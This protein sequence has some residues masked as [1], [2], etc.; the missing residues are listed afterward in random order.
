MIYIFLFLLPVFL[1]LAIS[2]AIKFVY[3]RLAFYFLV[4]ILGL[5]AYG[6]G[7]M[8]VFILLWVGMGIVIYMERGKK[9]NFPLRNVAIGT[10]LFLSAILIGNYTGVVTLDAGQA[11]VRFWPAI[12]FILGLIYLLNPR[13]KNNAGLVL[14]ELSAIFIALNLLFFAGDDF[15]WQHPA[16]FMALIAFWPLFFLLLAVQAFRGWMASGDENY[17]AFF[18]RLTVDNQKAKK[19]DS[20]LNKLFSKIN[21]LLPGLSGW[22]P[23][24]SSFLAFMGKITIKLSHQDL[25]FENVRK[26]GLR[27]SLVAVFG[28]IELII[29]DDVLVV[30]DDKRLV[31]PSRHTKLE[32]NQSNYDRVIEDEDPVRLLISTRRIFGAIVLKTNED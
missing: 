19:E 14:I 32:M 9:V 16:F 23:V 22:K 30:T 27:L 29:P 15:T 2:I 6:T 18:R 13:R 17:L 25:A 5:F 10:L 12:P 11:F 1:L 21:F 4:F 24:E 7:N 31:K 28:K 8:V 20:S 26:K 3:W